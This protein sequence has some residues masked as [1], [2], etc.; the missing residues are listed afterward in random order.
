MNIQEG[1]LTLLSILSALCILV[2]IVGIG[3]EF[4]LILNKT[5]IKFLLKMFDISGWY[6]VWKLFLSRFKLVQELLGLMSDSPAK[7]S[8]SAKLSKAKKLRKD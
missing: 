6:L 1:L 5:N 4:I 3:F 8:D 2:L 7:T